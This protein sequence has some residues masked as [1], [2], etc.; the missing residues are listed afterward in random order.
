MKKHNPVALV[1]LDGW[2]HNPSP[3]FNA[4]AA[5]A[6]ETYFSLLNTCPHT[7]LEASG[8]AVGL[9]PGV[10]GGSEVGHLTIGAGRVVLQSCALID[11]AMASGVFAHNPLLMNL[12]ERC[13]KT[14]TR[15][16]LLGLL[17]DGGIH[18]HERHLHALIKAA[19]QHDPFPLF[20]HAFLDGRDVPPHSSPIYLERLQTCF[21][22]THRGILASKTGRWYAMDRDRNFNRV[23]PVYQLL[24]GA[25]SEVAPLVAETTDE[26]VCPTLLERDGVIREGDVLIFFNFRPDRMR[27]LFSL[28]WKQQQSYDSIMSMMRYDASFDNPVLFEPESIEST[29][30]DFLAAHQIS[31]FTIAET[32]KYAHVTYFFNGA[33]VATDQPSPYETRMLIPSHKV[34]SYDQDPCMSAPEI[35]A[36]VLHSLHENPAQFYLINYAN[37]DMVG[38]SGNFDA[39]V[40][41]IRCLDVQLAALVRAFVHERNGVLC[42]TAD[43][44]KAELMFD[45]A[46]GVMRTAHTF[47]PVPFIVV[48]NCDVQLLPENT[49][50]NIKPFLEKVLTSSR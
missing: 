7:F 39:T 46:H 27:E 17:S 29:F 47:S 44:G 16:H 15:V 33:H 10:L 42:I 34:A 49:I 30:S 20:V 2:G 37:A 23:E 5:A 38:H 26:F 50:A 24:T 35:T 12:F 25:I 3:R 8:P 45:E 40:Q 1:I 14:K 4:I 19:A 21:D 11:A 6:P 31:R 9:P 43:H 48:G 22:Q 28:F 13:G 18:S 32:E 41:A 36:A